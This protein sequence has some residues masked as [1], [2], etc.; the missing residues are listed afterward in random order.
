MKKGRDPNFYDA[1]MFSPLPSHDESHLPATSIVPFLRNAAIL[2]NTLAPPLSLAVAP[3]SLSARLGGLVSLSAPSFGMGGMSSG[4]GLG[5]FGPGGGLASGGLVPA[6]GAQG[7]GVMGS[8]GGGIS[9]ALRESRLA[10]AHLGE[11]GDSFMMPSSSFGLSS[12]DRLRRIQ[13]LQ[14]LEMEHQ[15]KLER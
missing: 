8:R 11:Q 1:D 15:L 4:L 13:E 5:L 6:A 7:L 2:P 10:V 9:V 3:P 14:A 12:L